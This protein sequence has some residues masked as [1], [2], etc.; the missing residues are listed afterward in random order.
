M[1]SYIKS[2]KYGK[3][4]AAVL[5]STICLMLMAGF[6]VYNAFA[7]NDSADAVKT[8]FFYTTDTNGEDVF[9][10]SADM[11]ELANSDI[12][13]GQ[14]DGGN[15]YASLFDS[16]PALNYI[17]GQGIT[18]DDF[19]AYMV[20]KSAWDSAEK[21]TFNENNNL[22]D[23]FGYKATDASL[24]ND[25][26]VKNV[27]TTKRY[28]YPALYEYYQGGWSLS[29]EDIPAIK[30]SAVEM[31]V[32]LAVK[33]SSGRVL[34]SPVKDA[35]EANQ[36]VVTGCLK[37]SLAM[38]NA[39]RLV[40]P[41]TENE[42]HNTD[43]GSFTP[44]AGK[45]NKWIWQTRVKY[46]DK[47]HSPIT[48]L[49]ALEAP[50]CKIVL[51]GTTLKITFDCAAEGAEIYHSLETDGDT[52]TAS[53]VAQNKYDGRAIEIPNYDPTNPIKIYYRAVKPGYTD[54]GIQTADSSDYETPSVEG[55]PDF[56]Y[57]LGSDESV[58]IKV[59][60]SLTRSPYILADEA[61]K[62][63]GMEYQIKVPAAY[64]SVAVNNVADGWQY[65]EAV[66]DGSKVLTFIYLNTEGT[67]IPANEKIKLA[68][69]T[70][71]PLTTGTADVTFG[72][73]TVTKED[74]SVY[75]N[76]K[77]TGLQCVISGNTT[78]P[79]EGAW[80]GTTDISWYNRTDTEFH[81]TTPEQ[82]AGLAYIVNQGN[83]LQ[84]EGET[85][86]QQETFTDKIIYLDND[87]YLNAYKV[88]G[89]DPAAHQWPSIAGGDATKNQNAVFDG[90]FDGQN[91]IIYNMYIYDTTSYNQY[92][93]RNRG[94]FGV[95]AE[96]AEIKN[97]TVQD[98]YVRAARSA[99]GIVGKT[100]NL[101][102]DTYNAERD[103]DGTRI[104]NCHNVNT[105]VI[106]SDSKGVGGIC[107]AAWNFAVISNCSNSGAVSST[108][109]Y[110]AGG[111]AGESEYIIES[112]VN[113]GAVSSADGNAGGIV[114]SNKN[115]ASAINNC[116]NTG[117]ID[118]KTAGGITAY[119]VGTSKNCYSNGLIN[120]ISAGAIFGEQSS[121]LSN[122]NNYYLDN[123]AQG[124][125]LLTKGSDTTVKKSEA[126][127][128]DLSDTLGD[129][130]AADSK[131]INEGYPILKWQAEKGYFMSAVSDKAIVRA[132]ESF[133]VSILVD[134]TDQSD[135]G[136]AQGVLTY[137][138]NLLV[139]EGVDSASDGFNCNETSQGIAIA[140]FGSAKTIP[141]GGYSVSALKFRALSN[142][143]QGT[144]EAVF[145][146][147]SA[148]VVPNGQQI[149]SEASAVGDTVKIQVGSSGS[150]DTAADS[151]SVPDIKG[152]KA[153][154]A[155]TAVTAVQKGGTTGGTWSAVGL[156]D[157][158]KIDAD[159]GKISG[160]PAKSGTF[161]YTVTYT[162][163]NDKL[164]TSVDGTVKVSGKVEYVK[165]L[166][167]NVK[168]NN[169]TVKKTYTEADF[170]SLG[171][172]TQK[173]SYIDNLPSVVIA[174][175][176][177]VYI[178][179]ILDDMNISYTENSLSNIKFTATD[180]GTR[181]IKY[182]D[183]S[184]YYY[185][186]LAKA[187]YDFSGGEFNSDNQ[188]A[189]VASK[190][191]VKA[192]LAV[193]CD[194]RRVESGKTFGSSPA[195]DKDDIV[196]RYMP[197]ANESIFGSSKSTAS[198][199][200]KYIERMDITI[201]SAGNT[202]GCIVTFMDG[203]EK[204][205]AVSV[206]S[207][208]T[209]NKPADPVKDWYVFRGWYSD[210]ACTKA[211][212]FSQKITGDTKIYAGWTPHKCLA[213]TDINGHW[214]RKAICFAAEE[215]LFN[216][217]SDKLFSPNANMSRAMLVTV[218]WRLE[219]KP[220]AS[221]DSVFADVVKGSYYEE[222]VAW[223]NGKGI[224]KGYSEQKFGSDDN[225]TR[226]QMSAIMERYADYKGYDTTA[227]ADLSKYTDCGKISDYAYENMQWAN[228]E[229]LITGVTSTTLVP[230]G[231]ATRA[232]VASI[233]QRFV[234]NVVK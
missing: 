118:G 49:G 166:T 129:A 54:T 2:Q 45:S 217:T 101:K 205:S 121:L 145:G 66:V 165:E 195:G 227:A 113:K 112:C 229:G 76:V 71:T 184:G 125:G 27:F 51:D 127:L 150:S 75:A 115:A 83:E 225:I 25:I 53:T 162:T 164:T 68:D 228:A 119:Q 130:Y 47:T 208:G 80:D 67:D 57:G 124:V 6:S 41:L 199:S 120:G 87:I 10:S 86:A 19:V 160:T 109:A 116:Y 94:L 175:A 3:I 50:K 231:N 1:L 200:L 32:Y 178:T 202:T 7:K 154:V 135:F 181:N 186:D 20:K 158:L 61:C 103:G 144:H 174:E 152:A 222:A 18:L 117:K 213:F 140:G 36:G 128:K 28:Y 77:G 17:E 163:P 70:F 64:F 96:K 218:L 95:T 133:T 168:Y 176:K 219:D 153:G 149:G 72:D 123:V 100:G 180:G 194:W 33:S 182:A 42:L 137:D 44:T 9:I 173:Y 155:I 23:S 92:S 220:Q 146:L 60:E 46:A 108:G 214:A 131:K 132:G 192:M 204:L 167:V 102:N 88:S 38:E 136:G 148:M 30:A 234:E 147:V 110:P 13:H 197:V 56:E 141:D 193:E 206:A 170:E 85:A 191:E 93:A 48:A 15:Y 89:E 187:G 216:G 55:E 203:D 84:L 169:T 157:G 134:S 183:L 43:D 21:I 79:V 78:E 201:N 207:G 105:A 142:L 34:D 40:M 8:V 52:V 161:N 69:I 190:K 97:L 188:S 91:H 74:S 104:T 62:A 99:G 198:D 22:N 212:D 179:D 24:Y 82:L 73:T 189:V 138:K 223:A 14:A 171:L 11:S 65:G 39:L 126:E 211:F 58:K 26:T 159:T 143:S 156:P 12:C 151:I 111:I 35:V 16:M 177:G 81:I 232:E 226:E 59:G 37:D 5:I 90:V 221:A 122:S 210:K 196:F 98:G 233:L 106:T 172:K 4:I 224:V 114:G 63:Y 139:Y 230:Q 31:P 215:N 185:P 209:V 107:G 29:E